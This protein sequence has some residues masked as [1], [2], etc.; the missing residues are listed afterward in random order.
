M[1][2]DITPEVTLSAREIRAY[3]AAS[4]SELLTAL[5]PRPAAA[6]AAVARWC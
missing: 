4:V 3:G 2:G 6:R 5:A 1:A